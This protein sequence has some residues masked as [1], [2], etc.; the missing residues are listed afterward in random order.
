MGLCGPPKLA[1]SRRFGL[2]IMDMLLAMGRIL[3]L[4]CRLVGAR[5]V[6]SG[7]GVMESGGGDGGWW[8]TFVIGY[9]W[10]V[11][12]ISVQLYKDQAYTLN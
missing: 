8:I 2:S 4:S 7:G 6:E 3:T 9:F 5:L 11:F 12:V 1:A 10:L